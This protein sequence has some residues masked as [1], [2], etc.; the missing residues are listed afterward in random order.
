MSRAQQREDID[1]A[2]EVQSRAAIEVRHPVSIFHRATPRM[3]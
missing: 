3:R 2:Y 1:R